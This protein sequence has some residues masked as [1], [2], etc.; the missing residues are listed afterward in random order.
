MRGVTPE[1]VERSGP[2]AIEKPTAGLA[3]SSFGALTQH[4]NVCGV[5]YLLLDHSASMAD[6]GK[7]EALFR[8]ALHL[9]VQARR[10][11]Y[12]VG[13]IGF[14]DHAKLLLSASCD[15]ARFWSRLSRLKPSGHTAMAQAICLAIRQL[16]RR[17]GD[18]TILL[19]TDGMPDSREATLD[20]A[21]LARAQGITLVAI[22]IG[23]A[24]EAFLTMLSLRPEL[25]AHVAPGQLGKALDKALGA[26]SRH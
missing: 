15:G 1:V 7:M 5:V 19:V 21:R 17:T 24:D 9:F 22:G 6:E 13:L 14:A 26:I 2:A 3:R 11:E 16:R 4:P 10:R 18:K 8:G 12:S 25:A 23:N 20:A